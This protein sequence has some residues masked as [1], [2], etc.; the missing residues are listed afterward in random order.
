MCTTISVV[1]LPTITRSERD[2]SRKIINFEDFFV[3]FQSAGTAY[4]RN[5]PNCRQSL[6][7][8]IT[9]VL[10]ILILTSATTCVYLH[11]NRSALE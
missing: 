9:L 1:A 7:N 2:K 6:R 11:Q 3:N 5:R 4:F 8:V 10:R